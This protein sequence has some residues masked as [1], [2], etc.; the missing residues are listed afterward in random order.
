MPTRPTLPA[1]KPLSPRGAEFLRKTAQQVSEQ[2]SDRQRAFLKG[3][4]AGVDSVSQPAATRPVAKAKA[5]ND[6][7]A[8]YDAEGNLVGTVDPSEITMIAPAKAPDAPDAPPT[9][10]D[11]APPASVGTP[12][13]AVPVP[14]AKAI[15]LGARGH[16]LGGPKPGPKAGVPV[17]PAE[18]IEEQPEDEDVAKA[19]VQRLSSEL[20]KNLN[21]GT[22]V[23]AAEANQI[24]NMM[25]QAAIA[26]FQE[27]RHHLAPGMPRP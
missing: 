20:K 13:D 10:M 23:S 4:D 22:A 26:K 17:A 14:A 2:T 18:P 5:K 15:S 6:Q 1:P 12:A 25:Q 8:V 11:A 9:D 19:R 7:C 21:G 16:Q 27:I 3:F 24:A